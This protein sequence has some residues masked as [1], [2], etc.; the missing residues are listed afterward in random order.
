[1][2][3]GRHQVADTYFHR[4]LNNICQLPDAPRLASSISTKSLSGLRFFVSHSHLSWLGLA[5][6]PSLNAALEVVPRME[7]TVF[8]DNMNF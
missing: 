5:A 8:S 2:K 7:T 6:R 1:M 4:R 3:S